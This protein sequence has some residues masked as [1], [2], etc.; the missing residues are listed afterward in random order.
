VYDDVATGQRTPVLGAHPRGCQIATPEGRWLALMTG[1]DGKV[2]Q[3]DTER[4]AALCSMI[5]YTERYRVE[6][7]KVIT[8]VEAAWTEGWVGTDQIRAYKF[9]GDRLLLESPPQ[10]HPNLLAKKVRIIGFGSGTSAEFS[11]LVK[12]GNWFRRACN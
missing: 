12:R 2:P 1:E 5:A 8:R 10:P 4:S 11:E 9:E 3:T 7:R 6:D